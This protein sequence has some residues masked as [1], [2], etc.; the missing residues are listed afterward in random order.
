MSS[1]AAQRRRPEQAERMTLEEFFAWGGGGHPGKLE[2]VDGLV[3]A[4]AP[5]SAT[6][7]VIQGNIVIAIGNHLRAK[8]SPCRVMPEA[9]IQPAIKKRGNVRVPDVAVTCAPPSDAKVVEAPVLIVEVLS[10]SNEDDTWES[11]RALAPLTTLME[12]LVVSSERIE[13]QISRRGPDG[14]WPLEPEL[15]TSGMVKLTSI[16]LELELAEIYRGTHL[17]I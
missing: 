2:L 13:V 6:H 9:P 8:G 12:I 4:M 5:A 14:G 15:I 3:R 17:K 11:V 16:G 1:T 7:S 10:P